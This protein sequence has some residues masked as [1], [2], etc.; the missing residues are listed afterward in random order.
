MACATENGSS[1]YIPL[2]QFEKL[3]PA[4]VPS[5]RPI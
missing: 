2:V 5:N 3:T 1:A 4:P